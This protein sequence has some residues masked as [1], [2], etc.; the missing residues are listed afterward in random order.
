MKLLQVPPSGIAICLR[1]PV[2][3]LVKYTTPA[4]LLPFGKTQHSDTEIGHLH[5]L[6]KSE[7]FI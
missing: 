2:I 6:Y 5:D 4:S 7:E 3:G 1:D